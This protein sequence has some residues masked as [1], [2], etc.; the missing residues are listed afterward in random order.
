MKIKF[1]STGKRLSLM[2]AILHIYA[3]PVYGF[4]LSHAVIWQAKLV[5]ALTQPPF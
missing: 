4:R 1:S 5:A 2:P 3:W